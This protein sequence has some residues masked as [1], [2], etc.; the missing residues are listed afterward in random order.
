MAKETWVDHHIY[1]REVEIDERAG[2]AR[3]I[4]QYRTLDKCNVEEEHGEID[5]IDDEN[6]LLYDRRWFRLIK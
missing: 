6:I 3:I 5:M 1:V 2:T 4:K